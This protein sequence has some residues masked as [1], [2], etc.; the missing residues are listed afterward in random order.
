MFQRCAVEHASIKSSDIWPNFGSITLLMAQEW[1][2]FTFCED[3]VYRGWCGLSSYIITHLQKKQMLLMHYNTTTTQYKHD[4]QWRL[5][6]SVLWMLLPNCKWPNISQVFIQA[7]CMDG[8][9]QLQWREC[10]VNGDKINN[11][12][13]VEVSDIF[14]IFTGKKHSAE[15]FRSFL[16]CD[17][18]S[19]LAILASYKVHN[20][21]HMADRRSFPQTGMSYSFS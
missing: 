15:Y 6:L 9:R 18:W 19:A 20:K 12:L 1:K 17:L 4:W 2:Y 13:L 14:C 11:Q 3:H 8:F 5:C 21:G 16:D 10:C 7:Y